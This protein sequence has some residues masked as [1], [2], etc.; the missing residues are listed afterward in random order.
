MNKV[1]MKHEKPNLLKITFTSRQWRTK[2]RG[3]VKH[4]KE[5]DRNYDVLTKKKCHRK[6]VSGIMC[7]EGRHEYCSLGGS[8][9]D[10]RTQITPEEKIVEY[11]IETLP[12][13][14]KKRLKN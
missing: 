12:K 8:Y 11:I 1:D 3:K 2:G 7:R 4:R 14:R 6:R 10:L 9:L 13:I 5:T